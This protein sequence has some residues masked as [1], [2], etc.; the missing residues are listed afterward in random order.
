MRRRLAI[1]PLF[2][3]TWNA[4]HGALE[5]KNGEIHLWQAD[6]DR[7]M[8]SLLTLMQTL[9]PEEC[10]KAAGF[11]LELE[12][13][14]YILA[15]AAL[16][17]ILARYL[18]TAPGEL[19]FCYGPGGKP[20]LASGTLRFNVSH[21]HG[22]ALYAISRA[23]D[24]GVD[25]EQ[26]RPGIEADVARCFFS[27][28]AIQFLEALPPGARR[29]AFFRGWTRMEAYSKA[30]GEGLGL[31]LEIFE[32]FLGPSQRGRLH[33]PDDPVEDWGWWLHDLSPRRGYVAALAARGRKC[34][35]KYWKWQAHLVGNMRDS[36]PARFGLER[37]SIL[38][39][40]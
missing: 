14:R 37:D 6:L 7:N 26:V 24:V 35:L 28:R 27:P 21:S 1:S 5:L 4:P 12:R 22:L 19:G 8:C 3:P 9:T 16:R 2:M 36:I 18:K 25:V 11:R 23:R 29:R 39:G 33:T 10:R 32:I 13:N 38:R 34:R 31:G 17:T 15:R 40:E 30:R 20:E